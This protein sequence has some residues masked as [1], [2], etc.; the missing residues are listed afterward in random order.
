MRSTDSPMD[1]YE[2]WAGFTEPPE[3]P[4][5]AADRAWSQHRDDEPEPLGA[6]PVAPVPDAIE[7]AARAKLQADLEW[8]LKRVRETFARPKLKP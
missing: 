4:G 8:G 1:D 5:D 2:K 3:D 7:R 6:L